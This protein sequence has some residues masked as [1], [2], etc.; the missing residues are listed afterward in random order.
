MANWQG[1]TS[2]PEESALENRG[3]GDHIRRKVTNMLDVHTRQLVTRLSE[4]QL[5]WQELSVLGWEQVSVTIPQTPRTRATGT[6]SPG[7]SQS[8]PP[9]PP[10]R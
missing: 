8:H 7:D 2:E 9:W 5:C 6:S 4:G 1:F 10:H 3:P